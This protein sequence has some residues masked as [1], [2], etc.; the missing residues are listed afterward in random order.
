MTD[1]DLCL[2]LCSRGGVL[3]SGLARPLLVALVSLGLSRPL[4]LALVS[5][6]CFLSRCC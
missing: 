2:G 4:L 5:F 1:G 3:T 6:E